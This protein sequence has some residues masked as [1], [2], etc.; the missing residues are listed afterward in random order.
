MTVLALFS[1]KRGESKA[2]G[3]AASAVLRIDEVHDM[4]LR[5]CDVELHIVT[6]NVEGVT[7][8][9]GIRLYNGL[10]FG[11][12]TPH[13][14]LRPFLLN[15]RLSESS[16]IVLTKIYDYVRASVQKDDRERACGVA[17]VLYIYMLRAM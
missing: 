12:I 11:Y 2:C 17:A 13:L 5:K 1:L 7:F 16:K 15:T 14:T 3:V 9:R 4:L 10:K 6:N 8:E